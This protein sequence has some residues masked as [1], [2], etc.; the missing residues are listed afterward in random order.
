MA[1]VLKKQRQEMSA[2]ELRDDEE[3]QQKRINANKETLKKADKLDKGAGSLGA[4][5]KEFG[6]MGNKRLEESRDEA[7][8][9]RKEKEKSS[10]NKNIESRSKTRLKDANSHKWK[11]TM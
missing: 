7:R 4:A 5:M 11:G 2:R 10:R 8:S 3:H 6:A 1:T 9:M